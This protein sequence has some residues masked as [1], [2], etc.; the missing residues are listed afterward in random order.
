MVRKQEPSTWADYR[1]RARLFWL[2]LLLGPIVALAAGGC[3]QPFS[4][5]RTAN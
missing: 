1:N 5:V 4:P 2:L 3:A